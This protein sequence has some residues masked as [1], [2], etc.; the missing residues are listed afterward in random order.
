MSETTPET[1]ALKP[2]VQE[3]SQSLATTTLDAD[4][5]S[6]PPVEQEPAATCAP[7]HD[8][9]KLESVDPALFD[10]NVDTTLI[11]D[12]K[13][14]ITESERAPEQVVIKEQATATSATPT[15]ALEQPST[16]SVEPGHSA[17]PISEPEVMQTEPITTQEAIAPNSTDF[18]PPPENVAEPATSAVAAHSQSIPVD[19]RPTETVPTTPEPQNKLTQKFTEAEWKAL[20][21]FRAQLHDAF[22][23]AYPDQPNARETPIT[24]W[25]ITLDPANPQGDARVSVILMKFLRARHLSVREARAM[26]VNTLRW[27]EEFDIK[28]ALVEDF[29]KDIFGNVGYISGHDKEGRPVVYNIYGGKQDLKVVFGDVNRFIRWRVALMERSVTQLDFNEVDQTI[30]IHDYA[31]V[32]LSSRDANAKAAANEASNIFQSHYPELLYRKFF[33]NVPTVLSWIFWAFKAIVSAETLSKMSVVGTSKSSIKKALL[34]YID[35]KELPTRYG[36]EA[37]PLNN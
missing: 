10:P 25:G 4:S 24:L 8:P 22:A 23:E 20:I 16:T 34:P 15:I 5:S 1:N 2:A 35:L 14:V 32:T 37:E 13:P 26:L 31:G 27:R 17:I 12:S 3:V 36:G 9:T 30:Q 7:L 29:P 18:V 21:E 33:L 28:A 11:S 6:S 19:P